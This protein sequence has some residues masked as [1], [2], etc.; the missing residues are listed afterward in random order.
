MTRLEPS[1]GAP[2]V[3]LAFATAGDKVAAASAD[4][5][6]R[7]WRG[8]PGTNG[9]YLSRVAEKPTSVA[10]RPDGL[11]LVAGGNDGSLYSWDLSREEPV[12]RDLESSP[13]SIRSVAFSPDGRY[14]AVGSSNGVIDVRTLDGGDRL[15][16]LIAHRSSVN[17]LAF[18]PDSTALVSA[19]SDGKVNIF[20]F[21]NA[22]LP[23]IALTDHGTWVWSAAYSPDG[24]FVISA[25]ADN[26]VRL[27][28]AR[29]EDLAAQVCGHVTR[30]LTPDEWGEI[31][32]ADL[33][34]ET[35]CP[36]NGAG[37]ASG[38]AP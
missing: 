31:F 11:E 7:L 27:W 22:K 28:P 36:P 21:K 26:H 34:Y 17:R 20:D 24:R 8:L 30:N 3:S 33:P 6:V 38:G 35:I 2:V 18:S 37:I 9:T 23:P 25:G 16:P 14:L 15:A 4:G 12:A 1:P 10:F 13:A 5:S 29:T 19:S 32:P